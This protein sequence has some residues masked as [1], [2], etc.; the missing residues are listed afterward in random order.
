MTGVRGF[1]LRRLLYNVFTVFAI[2][3]LI[4]VLFRATPGD[5]TTFLVDTTF[6]PE[7]RQEI[8]R[9]FGLDKPLWQQYL[10]YW[11][12][13]ARG[14][15]GVSFVSHRPVIEEL[16]DVLPNTLILA[17][18]SFLFAY[19]LGALMGV[20]LAARRGKLIDSLGISLT[21]FF[22]SAPI[23]WVGMILL[24][25]LSFKLGW[26][27]A[28]RL[29]DVGYET[30][31]GLDKYLNLDFLHHLFLPT[32]VAGLYLA[33]LPVMLTRNTLLEVLGEDYIELARAKGLP[34][35][36]ILF[37][38]GF[39]NAILPVVTAATVYVGLAIAGM[40]EIE[41]VFSWPGVGRLIVLAVR[42][43]DYPVAQG[44]FL[45]L[46]VMNSFMSLIADLA[47][48]YLDPR[49]VYK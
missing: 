46:A 4:F 30:T 9:K 49:I 27:P 34:E 1:L 16:G 20:F 11:G 48:A 5:P 6:D 26:F 42:S 33:A 35:S 32:L 37:K 13:L 38:H 29:R 21:L 45:L 44:A 10:V 17:L 23:F 8:L 28:G 22:R 7:V 31:G 3:T 25:L 12:N 18:T 40:V 15:L 14:D 39:R 41:M 19:V 47:Y 24:M 43:H 36:V 2:V